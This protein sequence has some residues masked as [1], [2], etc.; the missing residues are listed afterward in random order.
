M[1]AEAGISRGLLFHYF[2]TKN[3][4]HQAV[5]EAAGRR[6]MRNVAPD[7]GGTREQRLAQFVERFVLQ[8]D[9]RRDSYIWQLSVYGQ[10]RRLARDGG[11]GGD[12]LRGEA[13]A[14]LAL[15]VAGLDEAAL[16][17]LH[18]WVAYV[19]DRALAWSPRHRASSGAFPS[20][21]SSATAR[22]PSTPC[23]PS[24]DRGWDRRG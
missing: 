1:A 15:G 5:V 12:A 21:T 11:L 22:R 6:V 23:W 7:E 24:T 18:G 9:R 2:P 10:H 8:L 3:A 17:V 16:P 20:T 13:R 4:F 14:R 19:E